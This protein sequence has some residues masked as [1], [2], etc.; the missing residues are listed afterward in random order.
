MINIKHIEEY[1]TCDRCGCKIE[2]ISKYKNF[3]IRKIFNAN[4]SAND[5]KIIKQE[6]E[7]YTSD[8]RMNYDKTAEVNIIFYTKG[9]EKNI[10]LCSK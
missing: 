5:Y 3:I 10:Q 8:I 9:T 4:Q 7:N 6:I 2:N 1:Y